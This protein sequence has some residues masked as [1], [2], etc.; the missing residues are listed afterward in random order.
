MTGENI[1]PAIHTIVT[2]VITHQVTIPIMIT[3]VTTGQ[4]TEVTVVQSMD[5]MDTEI[6]AATV[7][8]VVGRWT[9]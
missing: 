3:M 2:A 6:T 9:L 7:L 8:T 5:N 4:I 1:P